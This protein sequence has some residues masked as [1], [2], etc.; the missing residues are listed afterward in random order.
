LPSAEPTVSV[1][2]ERVRVTTWSFGPDAETGPHVHEYDY[3]VV[4]VTGGSFT[5]VAADGST[6]PLDQGAGEPYAGT[7]G[8]AHNVRNRTAAHVVFVEIELKG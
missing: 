7:A 3:L 8:T 2:D 1:D 5:V 6:R 4:P